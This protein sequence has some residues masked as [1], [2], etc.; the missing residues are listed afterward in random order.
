MHRVGIF[1]RFSHNRMSGLMEGDNFFLLR[2]H[3]SVLFSAGNRSR[4]ITTSFRFWQKKQV[5]NDLDGTISQ[6]LF[7]VVRMETIKVFKIN[8]IIAG[9][10]LI[11]KQSP[12]VR[13]QCK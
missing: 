8:E 4:F 3:H 2:I 11:K 9:V 5:E 6:L 7:Y 1:N 12:V 10:K 13:I